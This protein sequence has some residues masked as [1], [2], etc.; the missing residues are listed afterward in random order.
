MRNIIVILIVINL[1][2]G[3]GFVMGVWAERS[4][5]TPASICSKVENDGGFVCVYPMLES[6]PN[7]SLAGILSDNGV[8]IREESDIKEAA[9]ANGC[10]SSERLALL[11]AVR[12]AEN[13]TDKLAYGVMTPGVNTY[14]KQAG[15]AAATVS[16]FLDRP[17]WG[18][19]VTRNSVRA[20]SKKYCP[21]NAQTWDK[22]V[23]FWYQKFLPGTT[24]YWVRE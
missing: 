4:N 23:W 11:L 16:K 9:Q 5:N 19:W 13:G 10:W 8:D 22:N 14:R 3:I 18:G 12:K 21:V 1:M 2:F 15:W 17:E 20:L 7:L 24:A 6:T